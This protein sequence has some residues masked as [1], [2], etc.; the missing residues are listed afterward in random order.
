MLAPGH[1]A[2]EE[3]W[4]LLAKQ[5]QI[6]TLWIG[7]EST[8]ELEALAFMP[9]LRRLV[10]SGWKPAPADLFPWGCRGLRSLTLIDCGFKTLAAIEHLAEL[11]ELRVMNCKELADLRALER[12]SRLEVLSLWLDEGAADCAPVARVP[13]LRQL[14]LSSEFEQDAFDSLVKALPHLESLDLCGCKNVKK[15]AM[16]RELRGLKHLTLLTESGD[17]KP[18]LEMKH[19]RLLTLPDKLL[20]EAKVATVVAEALPETVVTEAHVCL[21]S[22]WLLLLLPAVAAG[23]VLWRRRLSKLGARHA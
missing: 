21:G 6:E 14:T 3:E 4:K 11:R 5:R 10:L 18:V 8:S 23:L 19:L 22:G 7:V 13:R 1:K 16:L 9:Q 12:L 2:S 20:K 17:L 15:L